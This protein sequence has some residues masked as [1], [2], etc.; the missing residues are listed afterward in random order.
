MYLTIDE[1]NIITK[2]AEINEI[3]KDEFDN[4]YIDIID[5]S[6]NENPKK[7]IEIDSDTFEI[8]WEDID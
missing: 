7:A 5:I 4:G 1:D 3:L 2:H 8:I 6:D